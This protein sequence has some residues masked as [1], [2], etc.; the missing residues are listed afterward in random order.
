MKVTFYGGA[1]SVTGANHL[2]EIGGKRILIDCGMQQGSKEAT[3]WNY[4]DFKYDPKTIDYLF[5][6]H[7]HIDHIGRVPKLVR[8]GFQGK[9]IATGP[10]IDLAKLSLS[11]SAGIIARESTR[12]GKEPFFVMDDVIKAQKQYV[13]HNYHDKMDLGNGVQLEIL[14]AGHVLGSA[15]F[16]FEHEGKSI[17][18]TGDLGNDPSPLIPPSSIVK[19]TDYLVIESVYGNR[20]HDPSN[21]GSKLIKEI[22]LETIERGGVLMIPTFSLER[23]QVILYYLNNLIESG[24]VPEIPVFLDSPLAIKMTEIFRKNVQY[25]RDDVKKQIMGGDDI[26]DFPKLT[27][28]E[29]VDDSKAIASVKSPKIILAG[30]GMS[31]AG[32]IL[33][34]EKFFLGG[35]KNTLLVVGYQA[36]GSIARQIMDGAKTVRIHHKDVKANAH[37]HEITAFSA[38]ADQRQLRHF[39]NSKVKNKPTKVFIVQGEE[40]PA[41][42]LGEKLTEDGFDVVIPSEGDSVEL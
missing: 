6:T 27:F 42:A 26:F 8:D 22:V 7:A 21:I 28:T 12:L 41:T 17:T 36:Q 33:H 24:E 30:N 4:N 3:L 1:K 14:N 38:H 10:T 23:S 40:E 2:L 19:Q 15:M 20:N 11:D 32:R 39:V 37:V 31:T 13:K 16:R 9:I 18:F 29:S 25:F 34:H 35:A 5:L